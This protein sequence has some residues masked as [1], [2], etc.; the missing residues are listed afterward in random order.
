MI[1]PLLMLLAIFATIIAARMLYRVTRRIGLQ[2]VL[3]LLFVLA[4][5]GT[6]VLFRGAKPCSTSIHLAPHVAL[7]VPTVAVPPRPEL[8]IAPAMDQARVDY[9][10]TYVDVGDGPT[11]FVESHVARD[12]RVGVH[13]GANQTVVIKPRRTLFQYVQA[14]KKDGIVWTA[15]LGGAIILFL[16]LAYL[17]L[18]AGTRGHFTWQLRII[19]VVAFVGICVAI[20]ALRG[21]L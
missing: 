21:G 14:G 5:L 10:I 2:W 17:F 7:P 16:Y 9:E 19:S 20:A 1:R 8:D 12:G 13:A 11:Q 6:M 15:I 18:D 4:L 3:T